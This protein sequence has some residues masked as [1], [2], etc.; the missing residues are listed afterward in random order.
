MLV[1][2]DFRRARNPDIS[3]H[4]TVLFPTNFPAV[5]YASFKF[6]HYTVQ[7]TVIKKIKCA[8]IYKKHKDVSRRPIRRFIGSLTFNDV[9]QAVEQLEVGSKGKLLVN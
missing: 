9:R 5:S 8:G 7:W 6:V 1:S 4:L 2:S 3:L